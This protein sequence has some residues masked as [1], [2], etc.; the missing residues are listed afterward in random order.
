MTGRRDIGEKR[1][2]QMTV[3]AF[4]IV[5][6]LYAVLLPA[7]FLPSVH[8]HV[9]GWLIGSSLVTALSASIAACL[10]AAP[11]FLT[12][13]HHFA[14][15][16]LFFGFMAFPWRLKPI[17]TL[18]PPGPLRMLEPHAAVGLCVL[19]TALVV[20]TNNAAPALLGAILPLIRPRSGVNRLPPRVWR[21][22]AVLGLAGA[23]AIQV[24]APDLNLQAAATSVALAAALVLF[25]ACDLRFL[26]R[27]A[28]RDDLTGLLN[29][30][31]F[32]EKAEAML[33]KA[34]RRDAQVTLLLIDLDHFKAIN[35][36]FGHAGGDEAL[37]HAAAILAGSA[38]PD[39]SGTALVG[40]LGGEEFGIALSGVGE[41]AGIRHAERMRDRLATSPVRL[42]DAESRED[43]ICL[44][45]SFGVAAVDRAA[46]L[47][48]D[49]TAALRE[50]DTA[51]YA[52]KQAGRNRAAASGR[53]RSDMDAATRALFAAAAQMRGADL[54]PSHPSQPAERALPEIRRT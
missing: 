26:L 41:E 33:E 36:R 48:A 25:A 39:G 2:A 6:L 34:T 51:L 43:V 8:R 37:R 38:A 40:R 16:L 10:G 42:V 29:R 24:T 9:G 15:L 44:T 45:A 49:I 17:A 14:A 12:A 3:N 28:E 31:A 11:V 4:S 20:A 18:A 54:A 50:A 47:Q 30:P 52:A 19:V 5:M 53:R 1:V 13:A 21:L 32:L 22:P 27:R 35:D 23:A 7:L 46:D